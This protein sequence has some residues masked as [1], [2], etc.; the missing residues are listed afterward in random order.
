MGKYLYIAAASFCVAMGFIGIFL[1]VFP[2]TPWLL[3]AIFL[4][5]RS[6]LSG[7]KMILRN[8]YLGPYVHSYFSRNGIP[9]HQLKRILLTLWLTLAVGI[10][11]F[12]GS[13]IVVCIL[14]SVG[15]GVSAHLYC[16]RE[17][18]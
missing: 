13:I 2:T 15:I 11:I 3:L 1:P 7:V 16:R 8:K 14:A 6:S 17:K 5:M 10:A 4:Y 12:R 18:K 9:A